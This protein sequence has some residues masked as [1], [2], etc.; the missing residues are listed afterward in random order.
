MPHLHQ[1]WPG[2]VLVNCFENI[3][4]RKNV[5]S[6]LLGSLNSKWNKIH[7]LTT[8]AQ[9]TDLVR[10]MGMKTEGISRVVCTRL[11]F[12]STSNAAQIY[13][14]QCRLQRYR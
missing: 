2:L 1:S 14:Q 8:L 4:L 12:A 9:E 5:W 3:E 13:K 10:M 11:D 6:L 7:H